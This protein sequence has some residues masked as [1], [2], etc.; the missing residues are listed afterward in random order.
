[1]SQEITIPELPAAT[2]TVELREGAVVIGTCILVA[3]SCTATVDG[4]PVGAHAIDAAYT[5]DA[6]YLAT[7]TA[8]SEVITIDPAP[9][10]LHVDASR[11]RQVQGK[12]IRFNVAIMVLVGTSTPAGK[13][14]LRDGGLHKPIVGRCTLELGLCSVRTSRLAPGRHLIVGI[15]PTTTNHLGSTGT[16]NVRVR[17]R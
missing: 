10:A 7:T 3:G 9:T 14:T 16:V 8:G 4:L 11:R 6:T 2:G 5:S 1:M 13:V 17:A 12:P 15:F